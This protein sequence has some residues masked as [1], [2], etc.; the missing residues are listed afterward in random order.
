MVLSLFVVLLS[1]S[2]FRNLKLLYVQQ[3]F[4]ELIFIGTTAAEPEASVSG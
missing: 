4:P 2:Q 1:D 3:Y